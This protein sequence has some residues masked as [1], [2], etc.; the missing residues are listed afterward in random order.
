MEIDSDFVRKA[1]PFFTGGVFDHQIEGRQVGKTNGSVVQQKVRAAIFEKGF[2]G[3]RIFFPPSAGM[4]SVNPLPGDR[5]GAGAMPAFF[6]YARKSTEEED[7]QIM[8]IES[9]LHEL[10]EYARRENLTIIEEFVEA[11]TA[12]E[13][14]RPVFNLMIQQIEAGKADGVLAWHPDRLA[15][16]SVDG[17]RIIYLIDIGK[18]VDLRF[19][20]YRT[21]TTAQG[22]F[23]LS[24][25]FGQSKYYVDSLSENVK[26][27]IREKLRRGGWPGRAPMGYLNNYKD[28]TIVPDRDKGMLVRK[29]F[30]LYAEGDHSLDGL[31]QEVGRWGLLGTTGK[32]VTKSALATML[33]KSFYYGVIKFGGELYEGSHPP[34]I[35]KK[36]FDRAQQILAQRSK[37]LI[38]GKITYPF[39]GLMRCA[40][41]GCMVTAETQKG[42]VYYH[43]TKRRGPCGQQFLREEALL[44]Q[45]KT[46]IL[47]VYVDDETT[48]KIVERWYALS[49]G[50]SK[51]SLFRS[52]QIEAELQACDEQMERLLDLYITRGIGSEEYQRKKAKLLGGK[53]ALKE[54]RDEIGT[55]GGGWFE[56]AKTFLSDCNRAYSVAWQEN[57]PA[58]KAFLKNC[59]SNFLL[60]DRTICFSYLPPFDLVVKNAASKEW[61]GDEDSNLDR[62]SQSLPSCH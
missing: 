18:I 62:Q 42:H 21:D 61:L 25:A 46:A 39:I 22:K 45:F 57:P 28:H 53:Q 30:E 9:Q 16:N 34:L 33:Q 27:G 13:P 59:G 19:P 24:I 12:K 1:Q 15:R 54:Q 2:P 17:G 48:K 38:R 6:L 52:R 10:R 20:T 35:S 8:S 36:L 5:K 50:S 51:A 32:P 49:E 29:A 43:C 47:K 44:D 14:G 23:M 56:P 7:R 58:Q 37:P 60:N 4:R 26:R 40:E 11:K 3:G 55:G 41:C 31:R